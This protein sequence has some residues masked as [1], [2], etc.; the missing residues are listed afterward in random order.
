DS[1]AEFDRH[2]T[3]W[4]QKDDIYMLLSRQQSA[5]ETVCCSKASM[6]LIEHP[7]LLKDAQDCYCAFYGAARYLAKQPGGSS[8]LGSLDRMLLQRVACEAQLDFSELF[9]DMRGHLWMP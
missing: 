7:K 4:S 1:L 5:L 8:T 3:A 9:N 6:L 2:S